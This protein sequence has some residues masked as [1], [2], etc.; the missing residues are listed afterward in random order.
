MNDRTMLPIRI[1]AESLGGTVTWNG[2]LQRVTI[3]KGA[4][5]ILITIGA[6][7]AYVNGTAVKLDA[8]AFV[9][10]GRTYLPMRRV[11]CLSKKRISARLPLR[12]SEIDD[13]M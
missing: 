3:Q 10:N 1:V 6:D 4:D 8:A 13:K 5:V 2:E 9:E 12:R 7:T 11:F